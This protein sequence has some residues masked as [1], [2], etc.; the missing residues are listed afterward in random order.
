MGKLIYLLAIAFLS[1]CTQAELRDVTPSEYIP[2]EQYRVSRSDI[3]G[4]WRT[5]IELCGQ[6]GC[7]LVNEFVKIDALPNNKALINGDTVLLTSATSYIGATSSNLLTSG[8]ILGGQL[9]HCELYA[10]H[11]TQTSYYICLM[12]Q[13]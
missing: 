3:T 9:Q 4:T 13:R 12:Y 7:H 11:I 10:D 2:Q 1:G 8:Q 6:I 5:D